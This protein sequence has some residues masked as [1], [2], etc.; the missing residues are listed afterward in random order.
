MAATPKM[1]TP[2]K[3]RKRPVKRVVPAGAKV[4]QDHKAPAVVLPTVAHAAG[5]DW[6]IEPDVL[7]D[8]ELM[9]VLTSLDDKPY[10]MPGALR[11]LLG[12]EQYKEAMDHLR[13]EGGGRVTILAGMEFVGDLL[14]SA[15]PNS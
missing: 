6:L 14:T 5:R 11:E 3:P 9:G 1:K 10:L 12:D 8:F 7:D 4:P 15:D 13:P 2:V